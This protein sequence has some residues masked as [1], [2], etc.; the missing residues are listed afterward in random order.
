MRL[1]L[2]LGLACCAIGLADREA[3]AEPSAEA[4]VLTQEIAAKVPSNWQIRVTWRDKQLLA[5]VTP[6]YQ[7]A[8]ELWYE[9]EKLRATMLNPC[10]AKNGALWGRLGADR[11]IAVQPTVG[12]KSDDSMRLVC[13][14]SSQPAT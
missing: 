11:Q 9:P 2:V 6:P 8:F 7:E 14:R 10:P 1:T 12:G 5:F 3:P 13:T 4:A